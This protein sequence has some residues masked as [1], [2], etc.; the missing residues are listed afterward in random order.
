MRLRG[1]GIYPVVNAEEFFMNVFICED[2]SDDGEDLEW[3]GSKGGDDR[4]C[5]GG[6]QQ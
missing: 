6:C 1:K 4:E 5:G 3:S 2:K